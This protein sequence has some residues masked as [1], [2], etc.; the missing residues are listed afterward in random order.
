VTL[1]AALD[2]AHALWADADG[3]DYVARRLADAGRPFDEGAEAQANL[4]AMLGGDFG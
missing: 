4:E 2:V 3:R 1:R